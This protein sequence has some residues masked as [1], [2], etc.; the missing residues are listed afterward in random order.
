MVARSQKLSEVF[1][2]SWSFGQM[3]TVMRWKMG[4]VHEFE[5][6]MISVMD[7]KH[8]VSSEQACFAVIP[9]CAPA[10]FGVSFD[11]SFY[12]QEL[13]GKKSRCSTCADN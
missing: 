10:K 2:S 5:L 1:E 8:K 3:S 11:F 12:P 13:D 7:L 6:G 9:L 4:M